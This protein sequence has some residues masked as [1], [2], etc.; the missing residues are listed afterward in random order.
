MHMG[1]R[2]FDWGQFSRDYMTEGYVFTSPHPAICLLSD[3]WA[4]W[5]LLCPS[6][7]VE[8]P[9]L[10]SFGGGNPRCCEFLGAAAV[11]Y[12]EASLCQFLTVWWGLHRLK[13]E[14]VCR[15]FTV[16]SCRNNF[17]NWSSDNYAWAGKES[18]DRMH[19]IGLLPS[20]LRSVNLAMNLYQVAGNFLNIKTMQRQCEDLIHDTAG[21]FLG[22]CHREF[23]CFTSW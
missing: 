1:W 21:C 13:R 22:E 23:D 18:S 9:V 5:I 20:T 8:E 14:K 7:S 17:Y 11:P 4:L 19:T 16:V 10:H 12:A 6:W 2:L 15:G 3:R